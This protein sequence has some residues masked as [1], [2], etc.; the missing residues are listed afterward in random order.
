MSDT[1]FEYL[2]PPGWPRAKGYSNGIVASGRTV[3]VGGMVG[4][5]ENEQFETDDFAGQLRQVLLNIVAVLAEA[6]ARPEHIV[7]MTWYIGDKRQYL[8]ALKEI[9]Q[10][11]RDII[12]RHYPVMAVIEVRGFIEDGA[13]LEIE[14]TAVIPS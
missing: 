4:W 5:N 13:R 9:G 10:A 1:S 14:T 2:Q 12:G 11:Y 7:R 3:Y 6:Q 8:S